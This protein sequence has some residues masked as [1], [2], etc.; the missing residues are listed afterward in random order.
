MAWIETAPIPSSSRRRLN[1]SRSAGSWSGNRQA[2]GLCA[3]SCTESIPKA[4]A[5]SSAFLIPPEQW[6]PRSLSPTLPEP[7]GQAPGL[8]LNLASDRSRERLE[9]LGHDSRLVD[10][11]DAGD[12]A[13][14]GEGRLHVGVL[15]HDELAIGLRQ[16]PRAVEQDVVELRQ[17][18]DR[19]GRVG[20]R[21]R[22]ARQVE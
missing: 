6:P 21:P 14:H 1:A 13:V 7:R 9:G 16:H 17:E 10:P 8:V 15:A 22:R 4:C 3:K 11:P 2:R 18:T 19:G 12:V 20:A 5:L